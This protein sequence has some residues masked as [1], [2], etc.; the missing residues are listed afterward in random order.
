M[1]SACSHVIVEQANLSLS[2]RL[3]LSELYWTC[4]THPP[5]GRT[6]RVVPA[7]RNSQLET[8]RCITGTK[9]QLLS[10]PHSKI[11]SA[12]TRA[13]C[14]VEVAPMHCSLQPSL[15]VLVVPGMK[16]L[17][18]NGLLYVLISLKTEVKVENLIS[19]RRRP[20]PVQR[21]ILHGRD[22]LYHAL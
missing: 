1:R 13:I 7:I 11:G 8:Q 3:H 12:S 19:G 2:S 6:Y 4:T 10:V 5:Y 17:R 9:C 14:F 16:D 21:I 20:A 22:Q 18:T 15:P